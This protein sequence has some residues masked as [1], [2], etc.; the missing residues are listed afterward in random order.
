MHDLQACFLSNLV[1]SQDQEVLRLAV[2]QEVDE[3]YL[4]IFTISHLTPQQFEDVL[5]VVVANHTVLVL[6]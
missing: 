2:L 5:T 1:R 6:V 4:L 3:S